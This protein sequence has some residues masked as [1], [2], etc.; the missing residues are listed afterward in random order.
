MESG[1]SKKRHN[2]SKG[3]EA[4][5]PRFSVLAAGRGGRQAIREAK[6]ILG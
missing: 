3:A 1:C 6:A 2:A 5:E 4:A